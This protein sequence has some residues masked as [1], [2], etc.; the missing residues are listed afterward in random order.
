MNKKKIIDYGIA[1]DKFHQIL[2]K[3]SKPI[4]KKSGSKKS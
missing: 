2:K 4:K 3:A 1:K